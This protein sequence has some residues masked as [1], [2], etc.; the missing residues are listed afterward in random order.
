[1]R[2]SNLLLVWGLIA[3]RVQFAT[4]GTTITVGR[5]TT[6]QQ[7]MA[8][9]QIDHAAWSALLGKYVNTTGQVDYKTWQATAADVQALAQYLNHL[10]SAVISPKTSKPVKLA[11]WINA[12]NA[13]TVKGILREY[14][15]SSIRNHTAKFFGYNIW[16]D[17][18]LL[19]ENTPYSLNQ[20]EHEIL[21]KLE[22]PRIHFAIVCASVGC[23]RLLNEAYEPARLEEQ[24]TSN[25]EHFFADASKFRVDSARKT[26]HVHQ[27]CRLYARAVSHSSGRVE[28]R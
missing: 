3:L 9:E 25:T 5:E 1:M 22:E 13:V 11:F 15:T 14:P 19:V 27:F 2:L 12:Y 8:V 21:R 24:L 18:Q 4:A 7:R 26:V 20:M 23:P 28:V 16:D 17:L 6:P 10:S